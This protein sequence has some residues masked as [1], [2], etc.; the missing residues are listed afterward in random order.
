MQV[1][2]DLSAW[3]EFR[4]TL[5]KDISFGFVPTM[6]NLHQGHASLFDRSIVENDCTMS[7]LFVNPT[8]FN[9][10]DDF[11]NYPQTLEEDLA[12]LSSLGVDYCVLPSPAEIYA[13]QYQYQLQQTVYQNIMEDTR[14]GHFTGVL[15]IVMKLFNLFKPTRA[16]FGEKDYQQ[17]QLI[18]GMAEAFFMDIEVIACPTIREKSH[19]ACSSR[20]NRLNAEQRI[21][22]EKYAA[23]FHQTELNTQQIKN[24]LEQ[25]SIAVDYIE[26]I[27]GRRF[28]AV[29]IGDVRLIDNYALVSS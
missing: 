8:Q 25:Q 19:L 14:S 3:R 17:L 29:N 15:T 18:R 28:I 10:P 6:G 12:L 21:L 26:E 4:A 5:S 2:H 20:N 13:D 11:K 9:R 24:L 16:Y 7:S 27:A 22:A 1:F 23:I